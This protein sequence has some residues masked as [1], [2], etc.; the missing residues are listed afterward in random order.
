M[1]NNDVGYLWNGID[2][3]A[4]REVMDKPSDEAISSVYESHSMHHIAAILKG[5]AKN[6]G[7][8]SEE[9]PPALLDFIQI[10]L[11]RPFSSDDIEMF[12][13]AHEVWKKHG[14]KFIFI[15]FFRALPYT[16]M[17][18][19][20]ANVLR[21]TRLLET[22]T[23]R[24]VIETAQF[25]FDV[26]D[27]KWWEP[28]KRGILTALKI[29][30]MH[31]AMRHI[32]LHP[33]KKGEKWN[34]D[35]GKPISQEDLVATNQVFSLE[36]F[37]GME[38]LGQPLSAQEQK[39]WFHTWKTIGSIMG[40]QDELIS[41]TVEE[42]WQLQHKIYDHLFNDQTHSGIALSKAL[43]DTMHHFHMPEKLILLLMKTMLADEQFPDCFER[44]LGPSYSD[45]Y[46]EYFVS[47]KTAEDKN[48]HREE[49]LH[50]HFHSHI[51]EFYHAISEK[52]SEL[53]KEKN[54]SGFF[55]KLLSRILTL[56]GIKFSGSHSIDLHL[57]KMHNILHDLESGEPVEKLEE[58]AILELISIFG[59]IMVAVLSIHFRQGKES[60]FRIPNDIQENWALKG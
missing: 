41:K 7:L 14:M 42:A 46:P 36:F 53:K 40:V 44:M 33:D 6:D 51:K 45:S 49:V 23:D 2:L 17:A 50:K 11:N 26:M 43:V 19:K 13:Q 9:L 47:H 25:V 16:Y 5:M 29:R 12:N 59:G 34:D 10:E 38:M 31:S 21:M 55:A 56:F 28:D 18:E 15:L 4:L 58:D 1:K 3:E 52:K 57:G 37:K 35:W 20:P 24:R 22:H 54:Q 30:I 32:I 27:K 48:K 8:V 60:G 39:A